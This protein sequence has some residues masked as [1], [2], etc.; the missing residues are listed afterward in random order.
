[1]PAYV[2]GSRKFNGCAASGCHSTETAAENAFEANR[3]IV[4]LLADQ[5]WVD[6]NGN[7]V[8]YTTRP[9]I[10]GLGPAEAS[11]PAIRACSLRCR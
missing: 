4:R 6:A 3:N 10:H 11:I 7:Q 9:R 8:L 5:L 1:M 2:S